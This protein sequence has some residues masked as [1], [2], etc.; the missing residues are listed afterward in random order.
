MYFILK[1][2]KKDKNIRI[3]DVDNNVSNDRIFLS[4]WENKYKNLNINYIVEN[5]NLNET[6]KN[7]YNVEN[8]NNTKIILDSIKYK[9]IGGIKLTL[10]GRL[11]RRYRADR[12][13]FQLKKRGILNNIV[14]TKDLEKKYSKKNYPSI[15]RGSI[16]SN[17]EYSM[18][19]SKR[20]V[21]AFAVK[22]WISG[23]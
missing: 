15:Y 1:Y 8:H 4:W 17:L 23:K 19:V 6:I 9:N 22:G 5:I 18:G 13:K 16:N 10:K 14:F 20:H 2:V 21:G 12:S 11:T 7:L 3:A